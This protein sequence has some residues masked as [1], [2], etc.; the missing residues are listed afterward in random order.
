MYSTFS[1]QT[2][3]TAL[4]ET[5]SNIFGVAGPNNVEVL[6]LP[7]RMHG[8]MIAVADVSEDD[9][10]DFSGVEITSRGART[11]L[12][13]TPGGSS[14]ARVLGRPMES[15]DY[16]LGPGEVLISGSGYE[17]TPRSTIGALGQV[18]Q[19][20][21]FANTSF[22]SGQQ[23]SVVSRRRLRPWVLRMEYLHSLVKHG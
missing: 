15:G 17:T 3:Y 19:T 18:S 23:R 5:M 6:D 9:S 21:R 12:A 13:R 4:S 7:T 16:E 14:K 10:S 8:R 1:I 22:H 20:P 11:P 2:A